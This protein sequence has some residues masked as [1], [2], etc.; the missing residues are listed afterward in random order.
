MR[1]RPAVRHSLILLLLLL[2]TFALAYF[3]VLYPLLPD[4]RETVL[5][6]GQVA[7]QDFVSPRSFSFESE[8]LTEQARLA[9]ANTI[10]PIYTAPETSIARQQVNRLRDTLA[11]I[12]TVRADQFATPDQKL[13]DLAA[14]EDMQLRQ[15]T[16]A[17]ILELS[18]TRWQALQQETINVLEQVMRNNIR[19][20]RLD[21]ARRSVPTRVSLSLPEEQATIVA[22]IAAAFTAPNSFFSQ[23]LTDTAREQARQAIGTIT[24]TYISGETIVQRGR[25]ISEADL[26]A[27]QTSGLIEAGDPLQEATGAVALVLVTT[28]FAVVYLRRRPNLINDLRSLLLIAILF[29]IFLVTARLLTSGHVVLPYIFP[30]AAFSLTLSALFGLQLALI[31]ILPLSVLATFGLPNA[32]ELTLF[33]IFGAIFGVFS[34]GY[35]RRL[36][37]FLR[38]SL[39]IALAGTAIILAYRL[40]EGSTDWLGLLTLASASLFNGTMSAG[41]TVL[42]QFF[43]AQ[44]LGMTT[45]L[46]LMELARPDHPLLQFVL[47][48][49][50]GTYQHSLQ[51][52]NLA[53]QAAERINADALLTRVGALYHDAGKAINPSFFIENQMAYQLNPHDDLDAETSSAI[54]IRHVTDGLEL[55][56]KYRLP[57][58]IKDF[59]AEHHGDSVTRYQYVKAVEQVDGDEGQVDIDLYRYPGPRPRS[60]ETA[61]LM[62]ADSSEAVTRAKTPH[63]EDELRVILKEVFE[64][65]LSEG[66]LDETTLTLKDLN[67]ILDSFTGTLKGVYHPRI[68]YPRLKDAE[69]AKE[70]PPVTPDAP[71]RPLEAGKSQTLP[72]KT[73]TDSSA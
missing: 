31:S 35:A 22:E 19:E 6:A 37:S 29:L 65:R 58:R 47:R 27:L 63:N 40:A 5:Q 68:E 54:I 10:A 2:A 3:A 62:L 34:L 50:P 4:L 17:K 67:E 38:A 15:E 44:F 24:R 60:R 9:A 71:T 13:S 39:V 53:E 69:T 36:S 14:L 1:L 46:Q 56:R 41:L 7:P 72:S 8:V 43:L 12:S 57:R 30:L 32:L 48:R 20:D 66:Q 51:V 21:E 11:Y 61:I 16:A 18:D 33:Y 45:P 59:I 64:A 26:E 49:A 52:A 42:L 25:V 70:L 73:Q 28:A 55:A 23:E